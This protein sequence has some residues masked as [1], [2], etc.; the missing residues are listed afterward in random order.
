MHKSTHYSTLYYLRKTADTISCTY[1]KETWA[2][3]QNC[4]VGFFGKD[5]LFFF[6][7]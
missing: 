4:Q 5:F 6:F 2:Q 3:K 1:S 7:I